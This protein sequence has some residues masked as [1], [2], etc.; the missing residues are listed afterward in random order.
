MR[1]RLLLLTLLITTATAVRSQS[2]ISADPPPDPVAPPSMREFT[3]PSHGQP[4]LGIFYL[5]AGAQLHPT[6]ILLHGFPGFEQNLDL[7]QT[8]RRAGW[9]VLALHY[10]GSW[11]TPGAFSFSHAIED[12]DAELAFI[13]DPANSTRLHIDDT[14]IVLIGH[15]MGGFLAASAA[16]HRAATR[17]TTRSHRHD[18]RLEHR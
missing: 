16:A 17:P 12:A 7:A 13:L 9:N 14:R 5:A 1:S 10:R 3:I 15:S 2:P 6:A 11:G 8:L 4:L 18:L